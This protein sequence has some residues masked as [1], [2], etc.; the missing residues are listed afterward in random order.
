MENHRWQWASFEE[1]L[2]H[3]WAMLA[4]GVAD[5]ADPFHTPVLGTVTPGGCSLRTVVLRQASRPERLL[6]CYSD[7]RAAKIREI[8]QNP[9]VSW[10]FY[11]PRQQVQLRLA[12][13]ATLH[14]G[15]DLTGREWA[16]TRPA[17]RRNYATVKAPGSPSREP[18]SGLPEEWTLNSPTPA[19][20]EAYRPNF[21][22]IACR[23]DVMDWLRL[24][25]EGHQRARFTWHG[26]RLS[27]TWLVP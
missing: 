14:T 20:S 13:P 1:I 23:V 18:T 26:D 2:E 7:R 21:A 12:G 9:R 4:A 16:A 27:A 5:A 15:D 17:S 6:I 11:H 3:S 25:A 22:V 8:R 24:R 19:E 10:L